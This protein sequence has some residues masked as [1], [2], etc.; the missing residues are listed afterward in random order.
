M[1]QIFKHYIKT[2]N[3][4]FKYA[5]GKSE[6]IG[7]EFHTFNEIIL[8]LKG[9]A[10]LISENIH[11]KIEPNTLIV[12]PKETY[13][14]VLIKGDP[15]NYCRCT[16]SFFDSTD[17]KS[18]TDNFNQ[19]KLLEYDSDFTY[20]FEKLIK[21]SQN[22]NFLS[23]EALKAYLVLILFEI[24]A[25]KDAFINETSQ[26]PLITSVIRYINQNLNKILTISEIAKFHNISHSSLSHIF[27]KEMNISIHK[28]IIKKRLIA[29]H[30]KI[31]YGVPPTTAALECGFND[32]SGF[33]KQ[34]KIM[35]GFPPSQK[36]KTSD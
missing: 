16:L 19:I 25:K 17:T 14:Q 21:Y 32:Y 33:Y 2:D 29:A 22:E 4:I 31:N 18:L 3:I 15:E 10:E 11:T 23:K 13:H 1:K 6:K 28:Y 35:F 30:H 12:I 5:S 36:T 9:N 7:K 8:F 20:I 27:K 24:N 34:Y 26:N